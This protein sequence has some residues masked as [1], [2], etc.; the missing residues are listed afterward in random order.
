M[1]EIIVTIVSLTSLLIAGGILLSSF[2][3]LSLPTYA[4]SRMKNSTADEG[5]YV[6]I[7]TRQH[8]FDEDV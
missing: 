8:D 2:G 1:T 6:R 3:V 4:A 7:K 5:N